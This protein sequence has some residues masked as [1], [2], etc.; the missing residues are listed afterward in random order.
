MAEGGSS[1]SKKGEEESE[2]KAS[3]ILYIGEDKTFF[4]N[5]EQKYRALVSSV[6]CVF[7]QVFSDDEA[8][9][10]SFVL[11]VRN[12][13]PKI[14]LIDFSKNDK[15]FLHLA[16]VIARQNTLRPMKVMGLCEYKQAKTH[17]IRG[18]MTTINCMHVKSSEFESLIY[19]I[20]VLAFPDKAAD[21]GFATAQMNDH[22]KA[23][24]PAKVSMINNNFIRIE[25]DYQ[26]SPKQMVR[27]NNFWHRENI[28][29][30]TLTM[31]ADQTQENVYYNYKYTQVMQL[32]HADPVEQT[33]NM[34]KEDFD[35]AQAERAETMENSK[36]LLGKWLKDN[37]GNSSPKFLKA[38]IVDKEGSF[39]DNQPQ[40]DAYS[41]V[42]RCQPFMENCKKE[43]T[44]IRPQLIVYN[45]ENVS[46]EDLEANADIAH[47]FNDSRMFQHLIKTVNEVLTGF[48]PI[49]IVFNT[50]EFDSSYMQKVYNYQNIMAVQHEINV[51]L[52]MK[53][54][55][56]FKQKITPNLPVPNEGDVYIDK[57]S[58]ISYAELENE[59]VMLACSEQDIYFNSDE[60]LAIGTVLR[61]SLTVPVFITVAPVPETSKIQSEYY[62]II[63]GIGEEERQ[64]LR[65][66]VN[67]IFFRDLE[68]QKKAEADEIAAQKEAY[69]QK[70]K[71]EEEEAAR[72]AAEAAEAE[73]REKAEAE[74]A[75]NGE[76]E[77]PEK[78]GSEE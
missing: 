51:D 35:K 31:C 39:F 57:T 38:Y 63:H 24:H 55:E 9:I 17:V 4:G 42:F 71:A 25:S 32:A 15:A 72:L 56:M 45:M 26:M 19:D 23:F 58:D 60:E 54:A 62:G 27:V 76:G 61:L 43:I 46:K 29:K 20:N 70:K 67:E 33:D 65:R 50:G 74:A 41:F 75:A 44:N 53:M 22:V 8:E 13:R 7:E 77:E 73:A 5:L 2:S 12:E 47:T 52:V 40:T 59:I 36:R 68:A 66:Y 11:K 34:T 18:I 69:V 14:V 64:E 10:Q 3:K 21:H 30:S 78:A 16:R 48:K 1:S 28:L 49:I 37:S 6:D